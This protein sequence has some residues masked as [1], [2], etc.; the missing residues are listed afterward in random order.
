MGEGVF[1]M[2]IRLCSPCGN[3][4]S[5]ITLDRFSSGVIGM[6]SIE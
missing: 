4:I 3:H 6:F 2:M 5:S 1:S